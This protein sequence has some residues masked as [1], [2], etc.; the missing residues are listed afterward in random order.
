MILVGTDADKDH[1]I[2][3]TDAAQAMAD[4]YFGG[5]YFEVSFHPPKNAVE[6]F[7]CL[8]KLVIEKMKQKYSRKQTY[9][10]STEPSKKKTNEKQEEKVH[11]LFECIS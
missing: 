8:E 5:H 3:T 9:V 11:R 2:I 10:D 6:S 7:E 1:R 4:R